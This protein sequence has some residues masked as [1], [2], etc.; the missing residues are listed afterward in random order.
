[1][2]KLIATIFA[3]LLVMPASAKEA[4]WP[5]SE[6]RSSGASKKNVT[7][8]RAKRVKRF[9]KRK[10]K[11]VA[12]R[13]SKRTKR[14]GNRQPQVRGSIFT[15]LDGFVCAKEFKVYGQVKSSEDRAKRSAWSAFHRAVKFELGERFADARFAKNVKFRCPES[16]SE[17]LTNKAVEAIG[18]QV[19]RVSCTLRARACQPPESD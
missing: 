3:V 16:S 5:Q 13:R 7:R 18:G 19:K 6:W 4:N 14:S 1:M 9:K 8:R 12:H 10:P 2:V 15:K 11:V 17:T